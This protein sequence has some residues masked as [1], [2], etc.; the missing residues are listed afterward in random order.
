MTQQDMSRSRFAVGPDAAQG[1]SFLLDASAAADLERFRRTVDKQLKDT[2]EEAS[3]NLHAI[4]SSWLPP[5]ATSAANGT[6]FGDACGPACGDVMGANGTAAVGG[7][8]MG[9]AA[10]AAWKNE[11]PPYMKILSRRSQRSTEETH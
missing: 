4:C 10:K 8:M 9:T 1:G 7:P 5:A 6:D 11:Q 2:M 3:R